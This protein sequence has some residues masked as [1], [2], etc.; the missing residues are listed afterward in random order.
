MTDV[1]LKASRALEAARAF[2]ARSPASARAPSATTRA[3]N[4]LNVNLDATFS[5]ATS[6]DAVSYTHLTLPTN[7]EV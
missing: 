4:A 7:R 6:D 2:L 5:A 3:R 1:E